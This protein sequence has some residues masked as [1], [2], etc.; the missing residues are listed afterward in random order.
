M[1]TT[2]ARSDHAKILGSPPANIVLVTGCPRS[3]TTFLG[4]ALSRP[5][6]VDYFHEPLNPMCGLPGIVEEFID[7]GDE[8]HTEAR[9]QFARL[10][11]YEPVLTTGRYR[12]DSRSRQVAKRFIGSRGPFMLRLGRIN[13]WTEHAVVKDPYAVLSL[14]WFTEEIGLQTIGIVRHPAAVAA[15]Y[16]RLGWQPHILLSNFLQR[17]DVL[18][19]DERDIAAAIGEDT[20]LCAALI[21]RVLVRHMTSVPT[22]EVT[23][24]ALSDDPQREVRRLCSATGLP[25]NPRTARYLDSRTTSNGSPATAESPRA[26]SF[27]RDS[28]SI[29][30][31][32]LGELTDSELTRIWDIAG[33]V[34]ARWYGPTSVRA[35]DAAE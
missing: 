31:Q 25:Y 2:T 12:R 30:R 20:L 26:Q 6:S 15:S 28:S 32:A 17:C 35:A 13:P 3:G 7:I 34:A 21:W 11:R 27:R 33:Q 24:E 14:K 5:F 22:I 19:D 8:A 4:A 18:N 10:M 23:H 16:R 9:D 1:A 29:F